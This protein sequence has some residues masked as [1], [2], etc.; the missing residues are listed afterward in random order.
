M[1]KSNI[2]IFAI[3]A[4]FWVIGII[5]V[6]CNENRGQKA[7]TD[8]RLELDSTSN[9]YDQ[10][11]RVYTL[12]GCEY[13][14]VVYGNQRW[15]SHKGNCK[16]HI[17]SQK[18]DTLSL[19][20]NY[21]PEPEKHFNCSVEEVIGGRKKPPYAYITECGIMFYDDVIYNEGDVLKGFVSPKHK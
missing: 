11:Y 7:P 1:K 13:I 2:T 12:E 6:S 20:G 17:N 19:Q 15:G 4:S 9:Y 16:N 21:V 8:N 18:S 10:N 5:A 3:V 14:V